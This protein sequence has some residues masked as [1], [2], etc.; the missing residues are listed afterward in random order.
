M[1]S[2][3]Q[4]RHLV[5][6]TFSFWNVRKCWKKILTINFICINIWTWFSYCRFT[7]K[8]LKIESFF[9]FSTVMSIHIFIHKTNQLK[10]ECMRYMLYS[11]VLY[12]GLVPN[13]GWIKRWMAYE[14][15][16]FVFTSFSKRFDTRSETRDNKLLPNQEGKPSKSGLS[17]AGQN[18]YHSSTQAKGPPSREP[19]L[20]QTDCQGNIKVFPNF[21]RFTGVTCLYNLP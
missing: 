14:M 10:F 21:I 19:S 9:F 16:Y 3:W 5:I 12:L 2:F 8:H 7:K 20:C 18:T 11:L 13:L 17:K 6:M 1:T 4:Q 15:G